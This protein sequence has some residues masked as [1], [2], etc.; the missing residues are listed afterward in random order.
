MRENKLSKKFDYSL[1]EIIEGEEFMFYGVNTREYGEN[2]IR[3][4]ALLFE[5]SNK[6]IGCL[7]IADVIDADLI[8]QNENRI[9]ERYIL[10]IEKAVKAVLAHSRKIKLTPDEWATIT[11][12]AQR[13]KENLPDLRIVPDLKEH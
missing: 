11:E 10:R 12:I 2:S 1:Q 8:M 5:E 7:Y 3:R 9:W 4:G 6:D 13:V